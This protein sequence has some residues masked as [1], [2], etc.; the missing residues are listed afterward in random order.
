MLN[1]FKQGKEACCFKQLMN[2]LLT[3]IFGILLRGI[4]LANLKGNLKV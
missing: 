2:Y 3:P 1:L 4:P